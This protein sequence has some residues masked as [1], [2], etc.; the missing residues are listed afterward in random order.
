MTALTAA[1]NQDKLGIKKEIQDISAEQIRT[2]AIL[3]STFNLTLE[4]ILLHQL[5][6]T[7]TSG[8]KNITVFQSHDHG[9]VK[10]LHNKKPDIIIPPP[11][12]HK[13]FY[14]TNIFKLQPQQKLYLSHLKNNKKFSKQDLQNLYYSTTFNNFSVLKKQLEEFTG[15]YMSLL[16]NC[17]EYRPN[18]STNVRRYCTVENLFA[19]FVLQKTCLPYRLAHTRKTV[20]LSLFH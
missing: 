9:L 11:H 20:T 16:S 14:P 2:P 1:L 6:E 13:I 10:S 3:R 4:I 7:L 5:I 8:A 19:I 12:T 18:N 15:Q 17:S